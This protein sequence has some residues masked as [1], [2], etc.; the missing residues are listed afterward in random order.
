LNKELQDDVRSGSCTEADAKIVEECWLD[1]KYL[2]HRLAI[3]CG[4]VIRA[5]DETEQR[6]A[7]RLVSVYKAA[8]RGHNR[9]AEALSEYYD[10][11]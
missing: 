3:A 6:F 2:S 11:R 4:F 5:F 7:S 8:L 10:Y 1:K 9:Y